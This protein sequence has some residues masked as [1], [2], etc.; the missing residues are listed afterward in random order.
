MRLGVLEA[1]QEQAGMFETAI[2]EAK[3]YNAPLLRRRSTICFGGDQAPGR[4]PN[5]RFHRHFIY[6]DIRLFG[7]RLHQGADG[8]W[9]ATTKNRTGSK[10]QNLSTP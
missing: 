2:R 3:A 9:L 4:A 8:L 5:W 1:S 10:N 6:E 7:Q